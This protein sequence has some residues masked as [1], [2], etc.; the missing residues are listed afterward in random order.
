MAGFFFGV[1][2]RGAPSSEPLLLRPLLGL[3][4]QI[5]RP[6]AIQVI[7]QDPGHNLQ[8]L[9]VLEADALVHVVAEAANR[10]VD[11]AAFQHNGPAFSGRR[12]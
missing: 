12:V 6:H 1:K 8:L 11:V 7:R 9:Q 10:A 2:K 3:Q 4:L 5:P